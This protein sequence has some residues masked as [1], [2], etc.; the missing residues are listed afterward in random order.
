MTGV[1]VVYFTFEI[2]KSILEEL[3]TSYDSV[4]LKIFQTLES[5]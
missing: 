5:F 4:K 1:S 3:I 2:Y